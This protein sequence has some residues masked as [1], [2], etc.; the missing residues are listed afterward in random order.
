MMN[1]SFSIH[2]S[3]AGFNSH[4]NYAGKRRFVVVSSC[5]MMYILHTNFLTVKTLKL[6]SNNDIATVGSLHTPE[7]SSEPQ[8]LPLPIH[9]QKL[10]N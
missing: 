8:H 7:Q 5:E 2:Y 3:C 4:Q 9:K 10:Q 1:K 6:A